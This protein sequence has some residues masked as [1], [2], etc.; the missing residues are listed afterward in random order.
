M[1]ELVEVELPSGHVMWA[2]VESAD[3]PRDVG[4]GGRFS[5]LP[6]FAEILEWVGT[7]VATGLRQAKPDQVTAEFGVELAAGHSGLVAALGGIAGKAQLTVTMSWGG[8][9]S[10][11]RDDPPAEDPR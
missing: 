7:G 5:D 1:R 11:T 9:G 4:L 2:T 8:Q 6:G 10:G 3:V